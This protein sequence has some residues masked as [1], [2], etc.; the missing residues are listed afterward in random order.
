MKRLP[1]LESA[2]IVLSG[3]LAVAAVWHSA[4]GG[5]EVGVVLLA[6]VAVVFCAVTMIAVSLLIGLRRL[7]QRRA[8]LAFVAPVLALAVIISVVA[9]QWPLRAGYA[10]SRSS[11]D[12]VAQRVRS[13]ENIATPVRAGFFKI[14]RAEVSRS[15]IVCLWTRPRPGGSTG[16]VQ[17]RGEV[18]PFNLWSM[19]G[20]D[21]RWQFISED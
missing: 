14:R 5:D 9:T 16:F 6:L 8:A 11:L 13:G 18:M 2:L 7:T 15:C 1:F 19:V 10:W 3:L 4:T 21:D 17:T 12:A 20:L